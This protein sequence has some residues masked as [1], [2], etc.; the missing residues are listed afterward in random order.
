MLQVS[1]HYTDKMNGGR[2]ENNVCGLRNGSVIL[3]I[4]PLSLWRLCYA[5]SREC[6]GWP[7]SNKVSVLH[8]VSMRISFNVA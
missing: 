2:K 5:K 4:R 7:E 8:A 3:G 6:T 1:D